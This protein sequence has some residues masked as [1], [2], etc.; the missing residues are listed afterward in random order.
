MLDNQMERKDHISLI[1][2]KVSRAIEMI[3]YAKKVLPTT[4]LKMRYFGLAEPHFKYC[5]FVWGSCGVT[6][7]KTLEKLQNKAICIIKNNAY[8]VS[9]GPLLTQLKIPSISDMITQESASMVTIRHLMPRHLTEQFARVSTITSRALRG[10]HLSIRPPRLKSRHGQNC[11][12]YRGSSVRNSLPSDIK[13]PRTFGLFQKK[14]K[15][16]LAEKN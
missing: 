4:F 8:D 2:S 15:T 7:R 12:A 3:K 10:S 6:T 1:S 5:S 16:M 14:L 13:S 9:I 11:F